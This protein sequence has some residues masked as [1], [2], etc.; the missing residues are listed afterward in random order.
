M[1]GIIIGGPFNTG[2]STNAV[3]FAT[4]LSAGIFTTLMGLFVNLPIALAPGMGLNGFFAVIA[5]TCRE[6][7]TGD[8][9]GFKCESWGKTTLPWSDAMGAI[10]IS[11][12]IYLFLTFTG[13]RSM[14]FRAVPQS[15]R[16]AITV[17]I[18]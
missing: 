6:N 10:F 13:L 3:F 5:K 18:G 9:N 4:A 1:N 7:P 16:S 11:G 14:L 2:L 15:L 12:G 17:G 8:I